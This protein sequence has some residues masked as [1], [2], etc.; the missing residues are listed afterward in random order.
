M[1][2]NKTQFELDECISVALW[3]QTPLLPLK[4]LPIRFVHP[5]CAFK[6]LTRHNQSAHGTPSTDNQLRLQITSCRFQPI[7]T[8]FFETLQ[9]A[10]I[11][12]MSHP[13]EV[14]SVRN[15][16]LERSF[17]EDCLWKLTFAFERLWKTIEGRRKFVLLHCHILFLTRFCHLF[18][19][20]CLCDESLYFW[21]A[22][23][24]LNSFKIWIIKS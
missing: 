6:V 1:L 20:L 9:N 3:Q 11:C 5:L 18:V 7:E 2:L 13:D 22:L 14:A 8:F 12:Q 15:F 24:L 17:G 10:G 21:N 23:I 4:E 16:G 19:M